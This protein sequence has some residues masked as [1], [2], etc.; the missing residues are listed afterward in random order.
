MGRSIG[1]V[2]WIFPPGGAPPRPGSSLLPEH[3]PELGRRGSRESPSVLQ[4]HLKRSKCDQ[5]GGVADV[6]VGQTGEELCPVAAVLAYLATRGSAP[7]LLF[8]NTENRPLLKARF[9][10][11]VRGLLD[12]IG[13]PSNQF[14]GHSFRICVATASAQAGTQ[15][16]TIQAL[17]RWNNVAFLTDIRTPREELAAM[18][19]RIAGASRE[20]NQ[21]GSPRAPSKA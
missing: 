11:R 2:F 18:S 6:L 4:I 20:A 14:A 10:D 1:S 19:A 12:E 9:V 16:S 3:A 7:G 8:T 21:R 15:D 17:G 13:Y 5:F